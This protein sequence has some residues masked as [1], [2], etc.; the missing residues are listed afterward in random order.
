MIE[1]KE[2]TIDNIAEIKAFFFDVFTKEP[3]NDDW[4][5]ENQLHMYMLDLTGN[6]N[7]LVYGFYDEN[8]LVGISIGSIKH[9]YS[10]TEYY[11]DEFCIKTC[12]QGKGIGTCFLEQIC[13]N[14][15][16]KGIK[17]IFLQTERSLP[18]FKFYIKNGFSELKE[19]V[20]LIKEIQ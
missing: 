17:H 1:I 13:E 15:R 16:C 3:W 8:E 12:R 5:D 2:L 19:H 10:G 4:S 11:I 6:R 20:S 14:I 9:W 7:S 18:A